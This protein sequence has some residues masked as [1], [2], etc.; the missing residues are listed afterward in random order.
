MDLLFHLYFT[1]E[2]N[3][4][5]RLGMFLKREMLL[6]LA[7]G[8]VRLEDP[9]ENARLLAKNK[10]FVVLNAFAFS[11]LFKS[12][13]QAVTRKPRCAACFKYILYMQ[14]RR[15][16]PRKILVGHRPPM[17]SILYIQT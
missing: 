4:R 1:H 7:R 14:H 8:A 16:V 9:T 15:L 3:L 10:E 12:A 2:M 13:V 6:R 11:I 17:L 5:S